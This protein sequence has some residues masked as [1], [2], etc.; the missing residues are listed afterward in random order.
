MTSKKYP[1]NEVSMPKLPSFQFYPGD[2]LK[3]PAVRSVSIAARGLWIDMLCLMHESPRRGYLQ[4]ET[5]SPVNAEQLARMTGCST[6]QVESL[7]SEL[8][9]VGVFSS[10]E[11]GVIYSRRMV[12]DEKKRLLCSEAGRKGGGNP[13]FKGASK[14]APK[15]RN[16]GPPNPSSSSSSSDEFSKTRIQTPLTPQRG[17]GVALPSSLDTPE[18]RQAWAEWTEHRTQLRVKPYTAK[19]QLHQFRRL[20]EMGTPKAIE[21]IRHS[22]ANNYLGIYE[23]SQIGNPA[24]LDPA[25]IAEQAKVKLAKYQREQEVNHD[26]D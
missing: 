15:G 11:R 17:G 9:N 12:R 24:S 23:P 5:G 19:G 1:K 10:A 2:W 3:D 16:K 22:M 6:V 13:T 26:S 20:A 8:D 18:F 25:S 21:A 7:L 14:G 4:H